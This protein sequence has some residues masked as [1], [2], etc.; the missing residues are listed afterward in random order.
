MPSVASPPVIDVDIRLGTF[1]HAEPERVWQALTTAGGYN[2]WFTTGAAWTHEPGSEMRW[3]W[4]K[5]GPYEVT[6]DSVGEIV[7]VEPLRRFAFTWANGSGAAP[8]TVTLSFEPRDGG[9]LVELVDSGYPDTPQGREAFM[10]CACG[11]GEAL[12]LAKMYVEH[13]VRY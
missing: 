10:D 11:W 5:W 3:H 1:V 6:T 12:T 8:S 13:G 4:E 7:A 9:T 2:Q